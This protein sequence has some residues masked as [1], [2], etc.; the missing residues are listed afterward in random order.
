MASASTGLTHV[1][2]REVTLHW[3]SSR[4]ITIGVETNPQLQIVS[5]PP[6][7]RKFIGQ[8]LGNLI[9]WMRKQGGF[10]Y[11]HLGEK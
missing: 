5:A 10:Q 6:I 8:A 2:E 4:R 9:S 7:A 1:V 3:L 11:E